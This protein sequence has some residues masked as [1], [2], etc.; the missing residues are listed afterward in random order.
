ML[1]L[2][3]CSVESYNRSIRTTQ[4]SFSKLF[5][6]ARAYQRQAT[7]CTMNRTEISTVI[8]LPTPWFT[9]ISLKTDLRERLNLKS[10]KSLISRT[11][12]YS[13]GSLER[14]DMLLTSRSESLFMK[15][16]SKRSTGMQAIKSIINHEWRYL[17]AIFFGLVSYVPSRRS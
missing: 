12:R 17:L 1:V 8:N 16:G 2:Y 3:L 7:K 6:S 13:L 14:R 10:R 9:C 11:R 15:I 5:S 4:V